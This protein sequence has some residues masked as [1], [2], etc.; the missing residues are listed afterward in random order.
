MKAL[1]KYFCIEL[2]RSEYKR[3]SQLSANKAHS[4]NSGVTRVTV[5]PGCN[6]GVPGYT[7]V[8][9]GLH[10]GYTR[11]APYPGL[12]P[13]CSVTRVTPGLH[14]G[15]TRV[16]PG[17]HLGYTRVTPGLHPG[18]ARVCNPGVTQV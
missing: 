18:V 11:V 10:L 2:Q 4:L 1:S 16:T 13:G 5:T 9:P 3:F 8:T 17:L 12:H 6:P 14:L 7:R 15:Y